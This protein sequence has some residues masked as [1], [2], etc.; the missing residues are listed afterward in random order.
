[1]TGDHTLT[2]SRPDA[3]PVFD[4]DS[5][6]LAALGRAAGLLVSVGETPPAPPIERRPD[7]L[8]EKQRAGAQFAFV[9]HAGGAGPVADFIARSRAVGVTL[10]FIPCIPIVVDEA[11]AEM[12]RSFSAPLPPGY[13][14]GIMASRDP[15][16]AGIEAAIALADEFL[17]IEGVVG[18]NL[19][20]G[21]TTS[22]A[23]LDFARVLADIGAEVR[24]R[25]PGRAA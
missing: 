6:E 18:V 10:D 3:Q 11:S 25:H 5:T 21:P 7:R 9:N 4:L 2:G 15:R 22:D 19:S 12:L 13:L 20:G 16:A 23:D 14:A 1:V 17:A 8:L 24:R